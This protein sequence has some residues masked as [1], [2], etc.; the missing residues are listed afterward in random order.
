MLKYFKIL[1]I[2]TIPLIAITL[3]YIILQGKSYECYAM[4][5]LY[6]DKP[7]SSIAGRSEYYYQ[8]RWIAWPSLL[9]ANSKML[10][11]SY[12]H[13]I[14]AD[15]LP[16]HIK[17]YIYQ[18]TSTPEEYISDNLK[19]TPILDSNIIELYFYAKDK[20]IA[21]EILNHII[22][23]FIK[24]KEK[25]FKQKAKKLKITTA[26]VKKLLIKK[27]KAYAKQ[28]Y[29]LDTNSSITTYTLLEEEINNLLGIMGKELQTTESIVLLMRL[30]RDAFS[31]AKKNNT[32]LAKPD[33]EKAFLSTNIQKMYRSAIEDLL[34]LYGALLSER[35]NSV[36]E[37]TAGTGAINILIPPNVT[38]APIYPNLYLKLLTAAAIGFIIS[39]VWFYFFTDQATTN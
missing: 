19:V 1:I 23:V 29:T 16:N 31:A 37:T 12:F 34:Q 21:K 26:K 32:S 8:A 11:N 18:H 15:S 7:I 3:L 25:Y 6:P 28:I 35:F 10:K 20:N 14:V 39:L 17:T 36:V 22:S 9:K 5:E 13:K 38:P 33:V 30:I 24:Q 27:I 4:L 2:S